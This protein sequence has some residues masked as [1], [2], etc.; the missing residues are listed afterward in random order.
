MALR[1]CQIIFEI[2]N[3]EIISRRLKW[4]RNRFS[5]RQYFLYRVEFNVWP[6]LPDLLIETFLKETLP[7]QLVPQLQSMFQKL[8]EL[9]DLH[10]LKIK[11]EEEAKCERLFSK[12]EHVRN[13]ILLN[14]VWII[15]LHSRG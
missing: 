14:F 5:F 10:K 15:L 11:Q 6:P 2:K 9:R 4:I 12:I 3:I 8:E 7:P 1:E 13:R